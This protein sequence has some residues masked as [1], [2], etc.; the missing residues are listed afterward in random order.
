MTYSIKS[1]TVSMSWTYNLAKGR[2]PD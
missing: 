1:L 2:P